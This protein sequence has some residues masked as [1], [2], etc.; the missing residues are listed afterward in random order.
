VCVSVSVSVSVMGLGVGVCLRAR[1]DTKHGV[2]KH[3][4]CVQ[5]CRQGTEGFRS[6]LSSLCLQRTGL[7]FRTF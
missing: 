5:V 7:R 1:K 4:V 3:G 6:Q 2:S